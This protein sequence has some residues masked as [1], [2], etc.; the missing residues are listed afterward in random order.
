MAWNASRE[1]ARAV[2]DAMPFLVA[3][4]H[5]VILSVNPESGQRPGT[6]G[7]DPGADIGFHLAR[8]GVKVQASH[9]VAP[10]IDPADAI[11]NWASDDG[12]DLIVVGAYG[13]A[14]LRELVLGGVTRDM[15]A[16]SPVP[17][18]MSH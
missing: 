11:L 9:G 16:A 7:A 3:A 14:R 8:H 1:A 2:A 12:I 5:V 17:L 6:H 4:Q 18:L 10:D 15:L 13:H